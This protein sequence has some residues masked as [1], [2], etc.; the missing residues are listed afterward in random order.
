MNL[1]R[2][3]AR[4]AGGPIMEIWRATKTVPWLSDEAFEEITEN[5]VVADGA[6]EL[7][8]VSCMDDPVGAHLTLS[9]MQE[10]RGRRKTNRLMLNQEEKQAL[11]G[12][13]VR[14]GF[15]GKFGAQE[16]PPAPTDQGTQ[17]NE[18]CA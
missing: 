13:R 15:M 7:E 16:Q 11:N 17:G 1:P 14:L 9:M 8:L 10:K 4:F 2:L 3:M 6:W 18:V 5:M 12:D